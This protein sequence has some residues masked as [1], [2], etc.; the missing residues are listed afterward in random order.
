MGWFNT[1]LLGNTAKQ[2]DYITEW[3]VRYYIFFSSI[4]SLLCFVS[5]NCVT[6]SIHLWFA[7]YSVKNHGLFTARTAHS[8]YSLCK[9][10]NMQCYPSPT[11]NV[12]RYCNIW[13]TFN[14]PVELYDIYH[15]FLRSL[16]VTCLEVRLC[17]HEWI[18]D[19]I[20]LHAN[21]VR[22]MCLINKKWVWLTMHTF[23][24]L[25][26]DCYYLIFSNIFMLN[27]L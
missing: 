12:W 20:F 26:Y 13:G 1:Y 7:G 22:L 19:F 18:V 8:L 2:I 21:I 4:S 17:V 11:S 24:T 16:L 3:L 15:L 14:V 25:T 27:C 9:W 6:N 10:S 5:I 23:H